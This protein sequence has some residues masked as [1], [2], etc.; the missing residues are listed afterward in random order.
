MARASRREFLHGC[1]LGLG[2]I[3]LS[4]L[5]QSDACGQRNPPRAKTPHHTPKAKAVIQLFMAGGPSQLEL[6][7][8]KPKLRE[9]HKQKVPESYLDGKRFAF[10]KPNAT[11]L[12]TKRK[13]GT[14]GETQSSVSE[15]LPHTAKIVDDLAFIK[16]MHTDNFN[17]GPAKLLTQTGF[18][19]FGSPTAGSWV[20]YGL[21]S[22][23][24]NLP[25]YVV[26]QSGP[27]G[28][29][30]GSYLWSNGF[31]PSSLQGVPLRSQGEPILNL[32]TPAGV[33]PESQ[34]RTVE[35]VAALNAQRYAATGDEELATRTASYEMAFRMQS[36]APDLIDVSDESAATL[37]M[38]GAEPG[39]P[40]YAFN[41]LL[42]RRLIERGV[43]YVTLFHTNWDHHGGGENLEGELDKVTR[44]IDQSSAALVNDLRQRG[45]LDDTIVMWGGEFGRTPMGE[46]RSPVGRDH[47]IEAYTVW[48]TGG[49]VKTGQTIGATDDLGFYPE[50]PSDRVHVHDLHA[51]LLHLLGLDHLRLTYRHQGR[52]YR[53]TDVAG[54]VIDRLLA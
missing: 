25:G 40:S 42:A 5:L 23:S 33:T 4:Q 41:C 49:G 11:L 26:L 13:F 46:S 37:E 24:T 14:Y 12:G 6:F 16:T 3:A 20:L 53:L 9:L 21:G 48:L 44:Q 28:P 35:A 51:T 38:Y 45:L 10:L 32:S 34:Q 30:G 29:R 39:K 22:E 8:D 54:N 31:L 18:Q 52:D 17:H 2:S 47:H 36:S 50:V 15:L 1:G 7:D 27:R 19:T 43:R